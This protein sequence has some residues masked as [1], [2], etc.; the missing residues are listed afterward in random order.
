GLNGA[1]GFNA[2]YDHSAASQAAFCKYDCTVPQT[3][4]NGL[5]AS[6]G[7]DGLAGQR[8]NGCSTPAGSILG[9]EWLGNNGT[10]GTEGTFGHGAGGGG[11][12]GCVTNSTPAT[13]TIGHHVGDLGA[14]GGGG[15]AGGCGG[16]GG[17]GAAAGGGSFGVFVVGVG[18]PAVRGNI[19]EPGFG[20]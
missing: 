20:G 7:S 8:G 1:G 6:N 2:S 5:P 14:T 3:G 12:G 18:A 19:I 17:L 11:A 15:G 4:L 13:C 16:S 9:G 10:P